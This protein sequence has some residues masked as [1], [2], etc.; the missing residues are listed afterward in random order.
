MHGCTDQISFRLIDISMRNS[1]WHESCV[2][3]RL[4]EAVLK[5]LEVCDPCTSSCKSCCADQEVVPTF[6]IAAKTRLDSELV[7]HKWAI[8]SRAGREYVKSAVDCG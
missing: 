8:Q 3:N 1:A 4:Y 2:A 7:M 6:S 5:E